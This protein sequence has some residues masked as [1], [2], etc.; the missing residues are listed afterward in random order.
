MKGI[1]I[2]ILAIGAAVVYGAAQDLVTT[3]VCLEYFTVA[4]PPVFQTQSPTLL[5]L[6]WGVIATWWVGAILGVVLAALAQGGARPKL[7][8]L[9]FLRPVALVLA[10][11]AA[12]ALAAGFA[13]YALAQSGWV[14][15]VEPL[16][17]Q[18]PQAK[19]ARF[20]ATWLAHCA[21]YAAGI[22]GGIVLCLWTW[23]KRGR[24]QRRAAARPASSTATTAPPSTAPPS[25]LPPA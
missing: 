23:R 12:L 14:W 19:H 25:P 7:G 24:L 15:L 13:G 17:S 2:L 21:A 16:K 6:G 1:P 5:A 11:M 22:G 3:R 9:D 20:I 10:V 18:I 8:A 4:H